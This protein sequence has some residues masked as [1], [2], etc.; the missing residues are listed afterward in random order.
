[1]IKED[2]TMIYKIDADAFIT[3]LSVS[4]RPSQCICPRDEVPALTIELLPLNVR[5]L[6]T[7]QRQN[8]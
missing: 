2:N 6:L 8:D 4:N 3:K 1:M 7:M 5:E